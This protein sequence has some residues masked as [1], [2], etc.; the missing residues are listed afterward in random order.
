VADPYHRLVPAI[1]L[2]EAVTTWVS[3]TAL[4]M[5]VGVPPTVWVTVVSPVPISLVS[6]RVGALGS[7]IQ[8]LRLERHWHCCAGFVERP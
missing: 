5:T 8:L 4:V 1:K 6:V 2:L 3:I 7:E